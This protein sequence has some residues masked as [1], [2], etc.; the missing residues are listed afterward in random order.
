MSM[1]G[2]SREEKH[3]ALKGLVGHIIAERGPHE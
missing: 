1:A 3:G 2:K